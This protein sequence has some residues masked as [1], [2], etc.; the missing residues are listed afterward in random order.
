MKC[1]KKKDL[2][3]SNPYN[4]LSIELAEFIRLAIN[5]LNGF[6]GLNREFLHSE[7]KVVSATESIKRQI[8][9]L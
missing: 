5:M 8:G 3:I 6:I 9:N 7:T 4:T 1:L 2:T